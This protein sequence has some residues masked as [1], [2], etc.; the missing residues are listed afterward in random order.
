MAAYDSTLSRVQLSISAVRTALGHDDTGYLYRS[1]DQ[2]RWT[3]VRGGAAVAITAAAVPVDDYEF[4]PDVV[5]YYGVN[6]ISGGSYT[7]SITPDLG[8]ETWLKSI[9]FPFLNRAITPGNDFAG[10]TRASRSG[11]FD[12]LGRQLPIAVTT[13]RG[14]RGWT[15]EILADS[16]EEA[17]AL[18]ALA[19]TGDVVYLQVPAA[20]DLPGGYYL[21]GDT[22]ETWTPGNRRPVLTWPLTEA[23]A[24]DG[25]ITGTTVIYQTIA[26]DF[27]TYADLIATGMT[28]GDV[29]TLVGQPADVIVP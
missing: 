13:A 11:S 23:A 9:R 22:S 18:D 14:G 12:I 26:D 15:L 7:D 2:I 27:A 19:T 16:G 1:L 29:L 17:D 8:G 5:N 4:A 28:Y 10:V 24:P 20:S 6:P 21:I 25:S 3:L